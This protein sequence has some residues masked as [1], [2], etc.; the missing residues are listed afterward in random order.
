MGEM[1]DYF[2]DYS[3]ISASMM[4]VFL[5]RR[6]LYDAYFVKRTESPPAA[7]AAMEIG[8]LVHAAVLEPDALASRYAVYPE[9][10]LAKNGAASTN[11]AREFREQN[12]AAGRVV[13]KAAD[14]VVIEA[15]AES[16]TRVCGDWLKLPCRRETVIR[17]PHEG[18][19]LPCKARIDWLIETPVETFVIDLKTTSDASPRGFLKSVENYSYWLPSAHYTEAGG[20][21][22]GKPTSFY[23]VAVESE[24]PY[25]CAI[26]TL[27][28][29]SARRAAEGRVRLMEQLAECLR[30][31]EWAEPWESQVSRLTLRPWAIEEPTF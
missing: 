23:F 30:T 26:H 28:A 22:T 13:M 15:I 14:L 2:T 18:T 11:A 17:W 3:A 9:S 19:A 1:S 24:Y 16:V 4:K 25:T 27:D 29:D 31:G 8:T 12:E 10:L 7:T 5:H 20:V 21:A 6:R